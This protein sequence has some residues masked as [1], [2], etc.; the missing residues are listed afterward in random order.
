M[1]F[2]RNKVFYSLPHNLFGLKLF[3]ATIDDS[4]L[5]YQNQNKWTEWD[6]LPIVRRR[7]SGVIL[8]DFSPFYC[9]SLKL[10]MNNGDVPIVDFNPEVLMRF[11]WN[12]SDWS[13]Q[14][15]GL[16][17]FQ[18]NYN[19]NTEWWNLGFGEI[20]T[21]EISTSAPFGFAIVGAKVQ[22]EQSAIL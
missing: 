18:G 10:I 1:L 11:S 19:W 20:L 16:V 12:G 22:V 5:I 13:D 15:S 7:R 3:F 9:N 2:F 14:V 4:K 6:D 17:G 21:V 8:Q